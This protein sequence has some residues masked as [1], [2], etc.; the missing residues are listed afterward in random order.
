VN[1]NKCYLAQVELLNK[2]KKHADFIAFIQEPYT[3]KSKFCLIPQGMGRIAHLDSPRAA[4]LFSKCLKIEQVTNLCSRDMAVGLVKLAGKQTL[5]ASLYLDITCNPVSEDLLKLLDFAEQKRFALL[6]CVDSNAH[7][8]LWMSQ[9]DNARGRALTDFFIE[10][11]LKI[12]NIGNT[13]TFECSTGKSI[14]D[15]TLSRGVRLTINEWR[16]CKVENHSDHHTIRFSLEDSVTDIDAHR[17]WDKADW[18][19]FKALLEGKDIK[20]PEYINSGVIDNLVDQLYNCI[21]QALD[22]SCP[23]APASKIINSNPWFTKALKS[24]RKEVFALW[25]KYLATKSQVALDRYKHKRKAYKKHVDKVKKKYRAT[26]KEKLGS[27]SYMASYVDSLTKVTPPTIGTIMRGDGSYTLPG[28]ETLKA[29]ADIHFT[30]HDSEL[31][32]MVSSNAYTL[33]GGTIPS[34]TRRV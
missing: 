1:L 22:D 10:R 19:R 5:L 24:K 8:Q 32:R 6:L 29:L 18:S 26:Y 7:G 2:L 33:E 3:Y 4:I 31:P 30:G 9:R 23:M 20:L 12:E 11:N 14:I 34:P 17:L 25:D 28:K 13:P 27:I 15:L 21:N 16:V